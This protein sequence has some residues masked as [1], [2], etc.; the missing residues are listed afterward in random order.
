MKSNLLT[1]IQVGDTVTR[2]LGSGGPTMS[3]KV[4][5]LTQDRIIC[6]CWEFS[7]RNGAEIDEDIGWNEQQTGSFISSVT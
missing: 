1:D 2:T 6:G 3:L 5:A 4:T 7:R